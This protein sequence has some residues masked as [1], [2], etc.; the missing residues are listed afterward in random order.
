[1]TN[2]ALIVHEH[3]APSWRTLH[4]L[5]G[6][7]MLDEADCFQGTFVPAARVVAKGAEQSETGL[8]LL[9]RL[10]TVRALECLRRRR[11]TTNR[12]E[13]LA[14]GGGKGRALVSVDLLQAAGRGG[15]WPS[16]SAW[17]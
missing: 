10:A 2:R 13:P 6:K 15:A 12:L 5:L 9:K 16:T 17:P 1:M 7:L 4:R 14:D 8:P 3:K 11:R